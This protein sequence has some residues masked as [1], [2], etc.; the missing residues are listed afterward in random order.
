MSRIEIENSTQIIL[1]NILYVNVVEL[2]YTTDLKSVDNNYHVGSSPTV[3][4]NIWG[5]NGFDNLIGRINHTGMSS[6]Y[7]TNFIIKWQF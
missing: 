3:D 1:L 6:P 5:C 2:A 7:E 4:T